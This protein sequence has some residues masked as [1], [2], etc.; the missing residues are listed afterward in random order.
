MRKSPEFLPIAVRAFPMRRS[1]LARS[2]LALAAIAAVTFLG[3]AGQMAPPRLTPAYSDEQ[4]ALLDK[5]SAYLNGIHSLKARF[6][7]IGPEGGA[8]TGARGG[9]GP[10][11]GRGG[12]GPPGAGRGG[13]G[14]GRGGGGGA[15][16]D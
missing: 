2:V 16:R 5:I 4:K 7:Q 10:G 15:R 14:G 8:G 13:A 9:R 1:L 6:M 3:A 11:R 12:G